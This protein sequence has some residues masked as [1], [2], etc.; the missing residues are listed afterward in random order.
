MMLHFVLDVLW[1]CLQ[2]AHLGLFA[3]VI[4]SLFVGPKILRVCCLI[5][6][7]FFLHCIPIRV[8]WSLMI[9]SMPFKG[10]AHRHNQTLCLLCI[11]G[12]SLNLGSNDP[13][14]NYVV[15]I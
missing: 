3:F 7:L 14:P 12:V 2:S 15:E 8:L 13:P 11:V 5:T 1:E 9:T 10:Q 6:L 4:N